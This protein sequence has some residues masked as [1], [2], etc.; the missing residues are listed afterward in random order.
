MWEKIKE[1]GNLI[2]ILITIVGCF[3]GA[4]LWLQNQFPTKDDLKFEVGILTCLLEKYMTLTQYQIENQNLEKEIQELNLFFNESRR[5]TSALTIPM[6]F[7]FDEKKSKLSE[8][9]KEL[10]ENLD[11]MKKVSNELARNVCGKVTR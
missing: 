1:F 10:K 11:N 2:T 7:L 4:F 8:K 6:T 5:N 3:L 9:K